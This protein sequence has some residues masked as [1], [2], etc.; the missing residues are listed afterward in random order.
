[1]PDTPKVEDQVT[2]IAWSR[3]DK[4]VTITGLYGTKVVRED[5]PLEIGMVVLELMTGDHLAPP[6]PYR[7]NVVDL[8]DPNLRLD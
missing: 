3:R 7:N 2:T 4:T 6:I 8:L 1:M 5:N